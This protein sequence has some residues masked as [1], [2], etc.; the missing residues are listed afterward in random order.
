MLKDG[1]KILIENL[2]NYFINSGW[3]SPKSVIV[4]PNSDDRS[5]TSHKISL[6][7]GKILT[8]TSEQD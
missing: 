3:F 4:A 7:N 6:S 2:M 1:K 5:T 8:L